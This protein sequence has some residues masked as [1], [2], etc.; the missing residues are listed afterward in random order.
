MAVRHLV[1]TSAAVVCGGA[2]AVGFDRLVRRFT[3]RHT[4]SIAAL[5]LVAAAAAYPALRS[6]GFRSASGIRE[7][8]ALGVYGALGL[9]A[10]RK[11]TSPLGRA[12]AGA[13]MS[14]ALFDIVHDK[15]HDSRIPDWYPACCAGFDVGLAVLIWNR[16]Q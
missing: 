5:T 16:R 15:G 8:V 2:G 6:S 7:V 1:G 10:A 14:H 11:P 12:V 13:W 4:T 3:P 9:T